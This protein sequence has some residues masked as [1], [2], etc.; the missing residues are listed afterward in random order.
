MNNF[1]E[2]IAALAHLFAFV[3]KHRGTGG[4]NAIAK[5]L[6]G[7]YN[8]ARFPFDLTELRRLDGKNFQAALLVLELDHIPSREIH[9][10]LASN[11]GRDD[12]QLQ[13]ESLAWEMRL[14][15][16]VKK[17]ELDELRQ[18]L[19]ARRAQRLGSPA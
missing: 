2:Q 4:G 14:K 5:L 16:A 11:L 1:A 10:H 6:L 9:A 19:L 7:L 12:I 3:E 17:A 18:S 13:L 8:G 15:K